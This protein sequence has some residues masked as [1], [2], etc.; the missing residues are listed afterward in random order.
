[1]RRLSRK[2][3]RRKAT[4]LD[5]NTSK[6]LASTKPFVLTGARTV[7][8]KKGV[9]AGEGKRKRNSQCAKQGMTGIQ[10]NP[11][12]LESEKNWEKSKRRIEKKS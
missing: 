12:C 3:P 9:W 1:M 8:H 7:G 2:H 10:A 4:E 5:F 6:G 11:S